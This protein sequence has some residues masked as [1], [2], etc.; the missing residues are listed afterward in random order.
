MELDINVKKKTDFYRNTYVEELI[1][2]MF[3]NI[4]YHERYFVSCVQ[5]LDSSGYTLL[6]NL[7]DKQT[8][9]ENNFYRAVATQ[10]TYEELKECLIKK[11]YK[12]E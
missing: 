11:L 2:N 5:G 10:R 3:I 1:K 9:K 12:N 7:Y 6:Y 4:N 8:E